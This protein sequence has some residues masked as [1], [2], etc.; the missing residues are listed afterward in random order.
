MPGLALETPINFDK[1]KPNIKEIVVF[2]ST[3]DPY[4]YS[5]E[6]RSIFEEELGATVIT[7]NEKGHFTEND[8][9]KEI[10]EVLNEF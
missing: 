10:K 5:K 7:L 3:N 9:V 2:L 4:N 6:N 8:N 1:I